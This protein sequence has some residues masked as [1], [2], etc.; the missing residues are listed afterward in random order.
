MAGTWTCVP[1]WVPLWAQAPMCVVHGRYLDPCTPVGAI[2]GTGTNA[3]YVLPAARLR[4]WQP[5]PPLPP[6]A[7]TVVNVE[8]GA[9]ESALLPR[10]QEDFDVDAATLHKGESG[11]G[12]IFRGGRRQYDS[13]R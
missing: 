4:K 6:G 3:C 9:F 7:Q 10:I 2:V 5:M 13:E 11:C 1:V 12:P 8:W